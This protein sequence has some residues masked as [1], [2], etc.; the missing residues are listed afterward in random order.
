[1]RRVGYWRGSPPPARRPSG[2]ASLACRDGDRGCG[3]PLRALRRLRVPVRAPRGAARPLRGG[4]GQ[5]TLRVQRLRSRIRPARGAVFVLAGGPGQSATNAFGGDAAGLL[6]AAYRSRDAIVFDQRGT[7]RSG[8]LRC[9]SLERSDL[10]DATEA[11][12]RCAADLGTR[13]GFYRTADSVEDMELLRRELGVERIAIYGTSYGTKVALELRAPLPG[14]RRAARA[15]LGGRGRRPRPALPRHVRGHAARSA[16]ALPGV[17]RLLHPR[18][19]RRPRAADRAP[20]RPAACAACSWTSTAAPGPGSSRAPTC[21]ACCS[22]GTSTPRCAPASRAPS[23]LRSPGTRRRSC[24]CAGGRSRSRAS[25][26]RRG[27]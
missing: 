27:C 15:R 22:P 7:G 21:S 5:L 1:M 6:Y 23:A 3:T 12:A 13:R 10:L 25:H 24:G 8:A 9:P 26:R 2:R 17:L 4:A 20:A 18:P 19:G 11:S 14:P 16:R